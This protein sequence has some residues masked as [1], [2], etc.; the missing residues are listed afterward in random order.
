MV[1]WDSENLFRTVIFDTCMGVRYDRRA[2]GSIR[3]SMGED[4][5]NLVRFLSLW[6][7]F[8]FDQLIANMQSAKFV[9]IVLRNT[10]DLF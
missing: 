5:A 1:F 8:R 2:S 10:S 9:H 4:L 3:A 6:L 7:I